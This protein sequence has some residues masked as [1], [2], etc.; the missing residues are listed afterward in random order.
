M[1]KESDLRKLSQKI[2]KAEEKAVK[3][4]KKLSQDKFAC[5]A[6]AIKA[7]L[8]ISKQFKYHQIEQS[9]VSEITS[10]KKDNQPEKFYQIFGTVSRN[11]NQINKEVQSAGR[12]VIATNILESTV[13]SNDSMLKECFQS[14]HL[15]T[16]HDQNQISNQNK[17]R[18]FILTLLPSDCHR[19]YKFVT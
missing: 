18:E 17:D 9:N 6:D 11:E 5:E 4:L 7:L 8:K 19:Y 16:S 2:I 14:I 3:E 15:V 12:F 13:L 10:N 1:R